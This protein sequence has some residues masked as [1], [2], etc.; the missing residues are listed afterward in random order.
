M[1]L[2]PSPSPTLG[3]GAGGEGSPS[4]MKQKLSHP[5][6]FPVQKKRSIPTFRCTISTEKPL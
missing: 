2:T 4:P 1:P 5:L 6:F 3:R